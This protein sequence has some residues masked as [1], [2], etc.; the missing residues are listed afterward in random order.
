VIHVIDQT[1]CI[2]CGICYDVCPSKVGAVVKISGEPVPQPIPEA[3]RVI[4][5][6][7]GQKA[8]GEGGGDER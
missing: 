4:E 5:R 3:E 7:K 6:G 1:K 8:K 2:K